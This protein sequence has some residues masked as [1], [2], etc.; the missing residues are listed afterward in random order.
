[1]GCFYHSRQFGIIFRISILKFWKK[2][3]RELEYFFDP[4]KFLKNKFFLAYTVITWP[5]G[6]SLV[7][8]AQLKH[9]CDNF[10][11]I[12][13]FRSSVIDRLFEI[14]IRQSTSSALFGGHLEKWCRLILFHRLSFLSQLTNIHRCVL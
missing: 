12:F 5:A 7:V 2:E 14:T 13:N 1:M 3:P 9:S 4:K 6:I 10:Y 8:Y 11:Y